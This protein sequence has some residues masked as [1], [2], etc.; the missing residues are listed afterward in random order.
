MERLFLNPEFQ[1]SIS[2]MKHS[3]NELDG[4]TSQECSKFLLSYSKSRFDLTTQ[5]PNKLFKDPK[6]IYEILLFFTTKVSKSLNAQIYKRL[7]QI[8]LIKPVKISFSPLIQEKTR[9]FLLNSL[10][11]WDLE[12]YSLESA[13]HIIYPTQLTREASA[14]FRTVDKRYGLA[15]LHYW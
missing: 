14:W 9:D 6:G 2:L 4:T 7:L 12:F 13:S 15:C 1:T 3:M 10:Q 5:I 11:K 8:G